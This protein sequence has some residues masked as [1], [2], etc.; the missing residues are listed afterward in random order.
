MRCERIPDSENFN[1]LCNL[2]D[3]RH[4]N[5]SCPPQSLLIPEFS[6]FSIKCALDLPFPF[7]EVKCKIIDPHG[8]KTVEKEILQTN[9]SLF[10]NTLEHN[11]IVM[12]GLV[13]FESIFSNALAIGEA[14]IRCKNSMSQ[15]DDRFRCSL[16][17]IGDKASA[18]ANLSCSSA[19]SSSTGS[20]STTMIQ[21]GFSEDHLSGKFKGNMTLALKSFDEGMRLAADVL[22]AARSNSPP[23]NIMETLRLGCH[24][25]PVDDGEGVLVCAAH[26]NEGRFCDDPVC[27]EDQEEEG[28]S[29]IRDRVW[30]LDRTLVF[31]IEETCFGQ[32]QF[33]CN[34]AE[35]VQAD[36][37]KCSFHYANGSILFDDKAIVDFT[38]SDGSVVVNS[39]EL[40]LVKLSNRIT[41][42]SIFINRCQVDLNPNDTKLLCE[43]QVGKG[44][45]IIGRL[46][47]DVQNPKIQNM[48][49]EYSLSCTF[50][51]FQDYVIEGKL[52]DSRED[53]EKIQ[54]TFDGQLR[55]VYR[56]GVLH[57]TSCCSAGSVASSLRRVNP[58]NVKCKVDMGTIDE[59]CRMF[60]GLCN[61]G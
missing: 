20:Y 13:K 28:T 16:F 60:V 15:E 32:A 53:P 2:T 29:S 25:S 12:D 22:F 58:V 36:I 52:I 11:E 17:G 42:N 55:S 6:K 14:L 1:I 34:M 57:L 56:P 24:V 47:C 50:N 59:L 30:E 21:C 5:P 35:D 48:T 38:H 7:R 18:T 26:L 46:Q 33:T 37:L 3:H 40:I 8:R 61:D 41:Y 54:I 39:V 44:A 10:F 51:L 23:W 19:W 27:C 49:T 4:I 45:Q 31:E 43:L 9:G